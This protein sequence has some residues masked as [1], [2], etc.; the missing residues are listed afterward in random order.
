MKTEGG[1]GAFDRFE[2]KALGNSSAVTTT[3]GLG[4]TWLTSRLNE[5]VDIYPDLQL[6]ILLEDGELDLSMR[7]G[8]RCHPPAPTGSSRT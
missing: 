5:F 2:G 8:R 4:S 7:G 6:E 1:S 3:V